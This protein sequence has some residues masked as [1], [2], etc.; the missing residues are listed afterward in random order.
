[1]QPLDAVPVVFLVQK[2]YFSKKHKHAQNNMFNRRWS[3][4]DTHCLP[5]TMM[6]TRSRGTT[7]VGFDNYE[8]KS[9]LLPPNGI[10]LKQQYL[11][12]QQ[13]LNNHRFQV[14]WWLF[15]RGAT[16]IKGFVET[17]FVS[18]WIQSIAR[19]PGG[20]ASRSNTL[21]CHY[22]KKELPKHQLQYSQDWGLLLA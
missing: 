1:M 10:W 5:L 2:N 14:S 19:F 22:L 3:N 18:F 8:S 16:W 13:T 21:C 11:Q 15:G 7:W 12:V 6:C 20:S 17:A 9:P 4:A